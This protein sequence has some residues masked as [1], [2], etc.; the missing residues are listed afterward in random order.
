MKSMTKKTA[1][2][3]PAVRTSDP[4]KPADGDARKQR[5]DGAEARSRLIDVALRLFVENGF[6]RT[7]TREIAREA[8]VNLAAI[9]YYFGDKAG[10][11]RVVFTEP[12]G[13]HCGSMLPIDEEGLTL[14]QSL[15]RFFGGFF[16]PLKQ[17]E[18]MQLCIR[19]H[20]REMIEPT[21]LWLEEI[22]NNIKPAHEGLVS[23]LMR[24]MHLS[25]ADDE[26]HRL[27]FSITALAIQ[28]FTSR[29]VINAIRPKLIGSAAA[30]DQWSASVAGYAEAMVAG[31][32]MRRQAEKP[33]A[34]GSTKS[35]KKA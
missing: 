20:F 9:K 22:N 6:S 26:V 15:E 28:M 21:G 27:A 10:L 4:I 14:R 23:A 1:A 24:H 33:A 35:R 17:T 8:G 18:L 13:E 2:A 11:Y 12:L 7:S 32:M 16:E 31:E 25:K 3:R 34:T 5:A 19:L 30:L 29:D